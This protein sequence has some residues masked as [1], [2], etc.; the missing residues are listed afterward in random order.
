[1]DMRSK[2]YSRFLSIIK[3][4]QIYWLVW[5][6]RTSRIKRKYDVID[7]GFV[8]ILLINACA[9]L[10]M[11]S[12]IS[13]SF[14]E[15]E[16]I[17]SLDSW[18]FTWIGFL[19]EIFGTNDYALR[20]SL[21]CVHCCNM[22]LL[23]MIGRIYLRKPKDSLFLVVVY[24]LLPGINLG[25]ILLYKSVFIIFVL[26]AICYIQLRYKVIP[27]VLIFVCG[28]FDLAFGVVFVALGAFALRHK[29]T[30]T[31]LASIIGF[32][33]N[34][35]LYSGTIHGIPKAHFLDTIGGLA[36][37]FSP[38]LFIY[39]IYTLY[40][41]IVRRKED[42]LMIYIAICGV[43]LALLLSLRQEIDMM[44]FAPLC[45]VG[46]PIM[47]FGFFNDMRVRLPMYRTRFKIRAFCI[48][49]MLVLETFGLY[50]NKLS[51]LVS[52]H[53]NFAS[54]YYIAKDLAR[55]L[56]SKHIKALKVQDAK[57]AQRLNFYGISTGS[58]YCLYTYSDTKKGEILEV[59]YVG[60]VVARFVL[61]KSNACRV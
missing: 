2:S 56:E 31:F 51:Y 47:V 24:A 35:Y 22:T 44:S 36:M 20:G 21:I 52:P 14:K 23:Y 39:Y 32:G 40:T 57:L 13:I 49:G 61:V 15:S 10:F 3:Y 17:L 43:V 30:K 7:L 27:Y 8:C 59:V 37:L 60:R 18:L 41:A 55:I 53:L 38:L 48:F 19:L 50:G 16:R 28:F 9:L 5:L 26:L 11:V 1:M 25:A 46:L 54:S 12:E 4:L 45:V 42:S 6:H 58:K 29:K 34:M 33:I